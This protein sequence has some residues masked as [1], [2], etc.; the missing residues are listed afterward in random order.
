VT[1]EKK[2]CV[3]TSERAVVECQMEEERS[4]PQHS[5]HPSKNF[6]PLSPLVSA[7][8]PTPASLIHYSGTSIWSLRRRR[9]PPSSSEELWKQ[10]RPLERVE[11][12]DDDEDDDEEA[13]TAAFGTTQRLFAALNFVGDVEAPPNKKEEELTSIPKSKRRRN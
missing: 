4:P 5:Q 9:T 1:A 10:P 2:A 12:D 11:V 8:P 13:L 7:S 3:S 6:F